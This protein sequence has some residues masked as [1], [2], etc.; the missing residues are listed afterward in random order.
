[1]SNKSIYVQH[2]SIML[3][4]LAI[5]VGQHISDRE[6]QRIASVAFDILADNPTLRDN[7][8]DIPPSAHA[9]RDNIS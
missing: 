7:D 3:R 8:W 2:K 5:E 4:V 1:M 6:A 9:Y